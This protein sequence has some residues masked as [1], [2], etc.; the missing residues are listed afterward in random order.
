M[1][2]DFEFDGMKLSV[3]THNGQPHL[4]LSEIAGALYGRAN[5][6]GG[7]AT[8]PPLENQIKQVKRLYQNHADEFSKSMTA[9]VLMQTAGGMQEVRVFSLRGAH[10]LGLFAET[11]YAKQFRHYVLNVLDREAERAN[12]LLGQYHKAMGELAAETEI[13]SWHGQGLNTWKGK[14]SPLQLRVEQLGE[15][16][17][18]RLPFIH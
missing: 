3:V 17:Q 6:K 12:S 14:K 2:D 13:A 7:A 5:A 18:L 11:S 9:N 10:L 4:T 8:A 15:A 16:L 1:N